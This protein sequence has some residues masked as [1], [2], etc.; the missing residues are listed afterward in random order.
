MTSFSN[1]A[2]AHTMPHNILLTGASGYLGGD[3]LA[4]LA[5][6]DL[7]EYGRLFALI[8]SSEQADAV[9]QL[10]AEPLTLDVYN[11]DAVREAVLSHEITVVFFLIN[12]VS[13]ASQKLFI[14]AL[15]ELKKKTGSDVHFLHTTGAKMFSSH[16]G[17]PTDRKLSDNDPELFAVQ[18]AQRAPLMRFQEALD[19][20]NTIIELSEASQVKSYIFAPC[21]VYGKGR[22]FGNPISIQTVAIVQAA[23]ALRRVYRTDAGAPIWP[24]SH[25]ADNT[26]LY[27]Q[28]LRTILIGQDPGHGKLGYYLASSGSVQWNDI[29]NAFGKALAQRGVIDDATVQDADG[30]ILQKMADALNCPKDF[31]APQ[32]GGTLLDRLLQENEELRAQIHPESPQPRNTDVPWQPALTSNDHQDA[33]EEKILDEIDWFAHTRTSDTPIWIGEISDAAFATR[34]RQ[35]ASS[36]Q[37][38]SHIPRTQF[39]SDDDLRLLVTTNPAWPTP[40]RARLLVQTALKFLQCSYHVVRRSEILSALNTFCLDPS[41]AGLSPIMKSKMWALFAL[42]ELR[43]S[44]C[45]SS[46]KRLPGLAY[47]AV[48]SD[49]V[50]MINE[51]PQLDVIETTLILTLY[52]L[53]ANRR[54]SACTLVGSA[55]RLATVM[56]LHLNIGD[57]YLADPELR[58]HRIRVWWSV[59]ILDRLLS[60]KIGLPLL[61]SDEDISVDLPSNSPALTSE[62]FGDHSH[63]LAI[64]RLSKIAGNISRSLYVRTPQ[65]GTF[66][67]RVARIREEL[68]HW[69][70]ELPDQV[71]ADFSRT[72]ETEDHSQSAISRLKVSFNQL[73]I[74]AT[75]PALLFC[76]RRQ[77]DEAAA[78]SRENPLPDAAR[79]AA[80]AC[81]S[82][83]QQSCQLLLRSW[84][85]GEF[86]TFDY[87]YVQHLFSAAVTL[88]IASTL[89][90]D[91]SKND[92]EEFEIVAGFLQQLEE[93]GNP[94]AMEFYAHIKEIQIVLEV[95]RSTPCQPNAMP[96]SQDLGSTQVFQRAMANQPLEVPVLHNTELGTQAADG[97]PLNLSFLDGWIYDNAFQQI[98]WQE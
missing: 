73:F 79:E 28:I 30:E 39:A 91:T 44:K 9:K 85:N 42:G 77:V 35:F 5:S 97:S 40:T 22:G 31:V 62:D 76:F 47:F 43:S 80:D 86:H 45:L 13:S 36:S 69:K 1:I 23:K 53:E 70:G 33:A 63:F 38:P 19:T 83:A 17:A 98:C 67:Q 57:T 10:G 27:V 93:T 11:E 21:I 20:N 15:G 32:L 54:H 90:Q 61:I 64:V 71:K 55:M 65:R 2:I 78:A 41:N 68:E 60:S 12:A 74:L 72:D 26:N 94:A 81:V 84:V 59:Y 96:I 25:I 89:G 87:S 49:T 37:T 58:E 7:P 6:T 52:S 18:K 92:R 46:S 16:S 14:K 75:R 56:G 4:E 50:R 95:W 48:A 51:R 3:L 8:R 88:A 66:L 29:Y 24:V 34:F 82:V